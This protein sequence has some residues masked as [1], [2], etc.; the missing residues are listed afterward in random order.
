MILT[1]EEFIEQLRRQ[2]SIKTKERFLKIGGETIRLYIGV[3]LQVQMIN[4]NCTCEYCGKQ[5]SHVYLSKQY[6]GKSKEPIEW[7]VFSM[8]GS[9]KNTFLPTTDHILPKKKGGENRAENYQFLCRSCNTKKG[10]MLPSEL[11]MGEKW[12]VNIDSDS[13]EEIS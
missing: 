7:L 9:H 1:I 2:A 4:T 13:F 12:W 5:P 11:I 3:R 8:D 10:H 6:T